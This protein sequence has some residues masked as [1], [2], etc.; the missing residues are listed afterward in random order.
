MFLGHFAVAFGSKKFTPRTNMAEIRER[1]PFS[2]LLPLI[3]LALLVILVFVPITFTALHLYQ[4]SNGSSSVHIHS[5]EFEMTFP[6]SQIIPWA[7]RAA[8]VPR[9]HTMMAINLP[10]VLIQALISLP[11]HTSPPSTWHP[12]AL[13]LETWR[14]LVFPFFALPF[15]WLV[16]CGLDALLSKERLHWSL[17]LIGT[18]LSIACLTLAL[19]SRFGM[20]EAER[21]GSDWYIRGFIGWTIGFATLPVAWILQSIPGRR[22]IHNESAPS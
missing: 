15:W 1:I 13:A 2:H 5:G 6:R 10:G 4:A 18:L 9:A 22:T 8:T 16:G 19:G 7:I 20:S 11:A 14:A 17:L 21:I 12:Q 3:D